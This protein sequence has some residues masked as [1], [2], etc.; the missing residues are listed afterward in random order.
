V[1][2][3]FSIPGTATAAVNAE[4]SEH[5]PE[6]S[7]VSGSVVFRTEDGSALTQEQRQQIS[8]ALEPITTVDRV[9]AVVDPFAAE[10]E[11]SAAVAQTKSGRDQL[12]EGQATLD[13]AS[14]EL[15]AAQEQLNAAKAAIEGLVGAAGQA[16]GPTDPAV[17][18]TVP[19]DP[20]QIAQMLA[21]LEAQQ[22]GLD[23]GAEELATGQAELEAQSQALDQA[24]QLIGF[25]SSIA[26]VSEDDSTA[27]ATVMFQDDQFTLP[28]ASKTEVQDRIGAAGITGVRVDYSSEIAQSVS[29]LIGLSEVIGVGVAAIVLVVLLRTFLAAL[30]P[31]VSS[32]AGAG[33]GVAGS[34]ALSGVVEMSTITPIFGIMLGLAVGI[35][36]ALFII[37]RHRRQLRAG[38]AVSESIALA[39][40]TAGNAVVFAGSTVAI[41]LAALNVCGIPFLGLM[42]WIGA[43]CVAIAV[44]AAIT[45][46]PALLA[47][48]GHRL[49]PERDR[50]TASAA[51]QVLREVASEVLAEVPGQARA[52]QAGAPTEVAAEVF[53]Q[54]Q[55][56][57][58]AG[59]AS[60]IKPMRTGRAAL[61]V[62]GGIAVL[63]V[64]AIPALWL[65]L[66][67]P[68]GSA[69]PVDS[70][71][72]RAFTSIA[73]EFGPGVNGPLVVVAKMPS[74]VAPEAQLASQAEIAAKL[75]AQPD[76]AAVA[77][78]GVSQAGDFLAFQ[79]IPAEGP[80]SAS[81]E[82]LVHHLRDLSPLTEATGAKIE[83]G[84][85]GQASGNVDISAK[86]ADALPI[87]LA[88]A[89]GLSLI[90]MVI[91]FRSLLVP[92][93][94]AG[95][96]VLSYF[97]ALGAVVAIYQWG[98]LGRLFGVHDPG[99]VL[100]FVPLVLVG[101]VFGLAMDYQ[102]FLASG[103]REAHVHGLPARQAVMVGLRGARGV[104]T[105]AALIMMAVF[106]GFIFSHLALVRP[107]GF[108]LAVGVMF[109]AFVVRLLIMPALMHLVGPG[110]WWLPRWLDR[111]LP[112]VD[113][114]GAALPGIE[115]R[116]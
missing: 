66:G 79:V 47:L 22:A 65:R 93:I 59:Q 21:E 81:T 88:V 3:T 46:T 35:D 58:Q 91:V 41:A 13:A 29:G 26:T 40:G 86:L 27:V 60:Q 61:S 56:A 49:L 111:L 116:Y 17:A 77:P 76:V 100:N 108:G 20:E 54:V 97:A 28:Q 73:E 106:G 55:V 31:L 114:E 98:I 78:A 67:L 51:S 89:L 80:A 92:L 75:M 25:A 83:L 101:V 102:L 90:I 18:V 68:D 43:A 105:A 113:V 103:M 24:G 10:A 64:I 14:A 33:I 42:G 82:E 71:S 7:G 104:V 112:N 44:L 38:M 85:A 48:I 32:L 74:P 37:Q 99:P 69:E 9:R 115:S 110:A 62:I 52:G 70:T 36:Y 95:G 2:S 109:D 23:A 45:L 1:S 34:M 4:L 53:A 63:L 84:V 87:Y 107:V 16:P 12:A 39:T 15:A 11:R 19:P 96:F 94:A 5:L 30:T 6:L 72:Y 57:A 8:Q 50:Q